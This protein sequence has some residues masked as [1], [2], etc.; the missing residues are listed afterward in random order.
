MRKNSAKGFTLI[1]IVAAVTIIMII[2]IFVSNLLLN[3]LSDSIRTSKKINLIE[4]AQIVQK[5]YENEIDSSV[6]VEAVVTDDKKLVK[7]KD[8]TEGNILTVFYAAEFINTDTLT[9]TYKVSAINFK[10][11]QKEIW[12]HKY[13]TIFTNKNNLYVITANVDTLGNYEIANY[14]DSVHMQKLDAHG[15]FKI[16]LNMKDEDLNHTSLF[17]IFNSIDIY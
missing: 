5:F 1:E 11:S 14:I 8:F 3:S 10:K 12:I 13:N 9:D 2:F 15:N 4:N 7:Y 16:T 17:T 6:T